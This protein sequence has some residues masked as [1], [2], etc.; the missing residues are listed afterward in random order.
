ME[1]LE[2]GGVGTIGKQHFTA[3]YSAARGLAFSKSNIL[4]GWEKASLVP[5]N[6]DRV[7]SVLPRPTNEQRDDRFVENS[8][9]LDSSTLRTPLTPVST[10]LLMSL[11]NTIIQKDA[12][13]LDKTS[14]Q[15]L[16]RHLKKTTKAAGTFH[17]TNTL[18]Q[19]QIHSLWKVN[20]EA[21]VRRATNSII[22]GKGRV[23]SYDDL[24]AARV[25]R[26]EKDATRNHKG[27]SSR[28]RRKRKGGAIDRSLAVDLA[29]KPLYCEGNVGLD[30]TRSEELS[31]EEAE[32]F[33]HF[34]ASEA[35]MY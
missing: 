7:L 23:M 32:G 1:R 10:E 35:R 2:R 28:Q 25:K 24:V 26:A 5:F 12:S 9:S 8:I 18:L 11:Q 6:R 21:K 27:K 22:L 14:K 17:A 16:E 33:E 19:K 29:S 20:N 4:A 34:E 15:N 31:A 30:L 13:L 3:L